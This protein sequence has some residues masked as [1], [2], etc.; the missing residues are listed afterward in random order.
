VSLNYGRTKE[1]HLLRLLKIL[2]RGVYSIRNDD[3]DDVVE[4]VRISDSLSSS[5]SVKGCCVPHCQLIGSSEDGE[6]YAPLRSTK[7]Q[8]THHKHMTPT[9][10]PDPRYVFEEWCVL[11]FD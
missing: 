9:P 2:V 5:K 8:T 7:T 3:D 1:T 4:V 10:I 11:V 6:G